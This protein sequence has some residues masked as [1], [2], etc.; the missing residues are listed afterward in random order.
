MVAGLAAWFHTASLFFF[1][2]VYQLRN[3]RFL[4]AESLLT[5]MRH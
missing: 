1:E 3:G 4:H 5:G 2:E